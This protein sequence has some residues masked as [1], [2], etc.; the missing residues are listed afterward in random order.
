MSR[1]QAIYNKTG[2]KSSFMDYLDTKVFH[3]EPLSLPIANLHKLQNGLPLV[4]VH[5]SID[6]SIR[7]SSMIEIF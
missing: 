3:V 1:H 4:A 5:C 6:R 7:K 2:L